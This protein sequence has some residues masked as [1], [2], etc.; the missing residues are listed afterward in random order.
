LVR[1][2][3]LVLIPAH[4]KFLQVEDMPQGLK[5]DYPG[6]A[7]ETQ[8]EALGY[9][10]AKGNDYLPSSRRLSNFCLRCE[11]KIRANAKRQM[12]GSFFAQDDDKE[13]E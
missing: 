2:S 9:L 13:E 10:E 5:P 1:G 7:R 12:R 11:G 6:Q 8:A 3:G 4:R